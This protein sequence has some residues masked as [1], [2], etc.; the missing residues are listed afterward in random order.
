MCEASRSR[1]LLCVSQR[2][3]EVQRH[4][5]G[6]K[7]WPA[8][9]HGGW[10]NSC[11]ED[12]GDALAWMASG[13]VGL[14]NVVS[15]GPLVPVGEA[16]KGLIQAGEGAA[17][18]DV[19]LRELIAWCAFLTE[20]LL[21]QGKGVDTLAPV[22]RSLKDFESTTNQLAS[23]RRGWRQ[24]ESARRFSAV[25]GTENR[26]QTSTRSSAIFGMSSKE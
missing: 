19:N 15:V 26:S 21:Q 4:L 14:L 20:V 25:R 23:V 17:E 5:E 22:M 9:L 24:E 13:A 3:E 12:V 1:E 10:A 11:P 2:L 6:R 7:Q 16:F 8:F 18:A